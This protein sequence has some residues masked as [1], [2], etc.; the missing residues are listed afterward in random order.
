VI[1]YGM[2]ATRFMRPVGDSNRFL[3]ML[4]TINF[5]VKKKNHW[6]LCTNKRNSSNG[7]LV[8]LLFCPLLPT[9]PLNFSCLIVNSVIL[10]K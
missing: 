10:T 9:I 8:K 1:L 6:D 5:S 4:T 2:N 7:R 3:S